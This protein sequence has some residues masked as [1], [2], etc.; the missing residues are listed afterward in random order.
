[1]MDEEEKKVEVEEIVLEEET[2][3]K[4]KMHIILKILLILMLL[5]IVAV[6][7]AY[8]WYTSSLEAVNENNKEIKTVKIESGKG[9]VGIAQILKENNLIKSDL[10]FKIYC[11]KNNITKLQS[12]EKELRTEERRVG[13][14]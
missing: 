8:F 10:S 1:M 5:S 2:Q 6:V 7:G 12:G 4:E 3:E 13:K 9:T 14:E 11:K